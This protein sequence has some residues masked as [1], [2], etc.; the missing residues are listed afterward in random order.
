MIPPIVGV[1]IFLTIWSEGPSSLIGLNIFLFE[2]NF[3]KGPPI[4]RAMNNEVKKANPVL[5]L[6]YLKTLKKVNV[7]T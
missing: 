1:P 4:S 3:I 5:N 2:N 7:S 6:I